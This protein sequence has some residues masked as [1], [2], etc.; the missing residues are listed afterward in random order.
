MIVAGKGG[1]GK[2]TVSGALALMAARAGLNTLVVEVE[3]K[4]GLPV[5]FDRPD[6]LTYR[7]T[8]LIPA[9]ETAPSG[10]GAVSARTLTPDDALLEYLEDHGMRRISK[11]LTSTGTLEVIATAIPGIKD[12]LVLGKIKQME[13][14][15]SDGVAGAVDFVVVDAPAAGHAVTFL[16]SAH[17]LLDAVNVGPIGTQ[18]A[19]VIEFISDPKRCQ[20]LLVTLPEETPVNEVI[21]TAFHL[22]DR[23][24]VQLA[25][26]VVN[27]SYPTLDLPEDPAG[28]V[29]SIGAGL[30]AEEAAAPWPAPPSS[31]GSRQELE[32]EQVRNG[33]PSS[34]PWPR[35]PLPLQFTTDLGLGG[36][37]SDLADALVCGRGR[38]RPPPGSHERFPHQR[39]RRRGLPVRLRSSNAAR[40]SS[41]PGPGGWA[42]RP[43]P[44]PSPSLVPVGRPANLRR[45]HRPGPAPGRRPGDRR[46]RQRTP[47]GGGAWRGARPGELWAL[48][49][50]TKAT[51]DAVVAANAPARPRPRPSYANR[52]YRNISGALSGT[53]EYMAMEKLYGLHAQDDRFDLVV[54]DTPPTRHA[55]DFLDA[56]NRLTCGSS[57]TGSSGC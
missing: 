9:A 35:S 1:V 13:Q 48:M 52:F 51:F 4:S 41:A 54:V 43:P 30:S 19:E 26:V 20:V 37:L 23:A 34:S 12:I 21:E 2:T 40:S 47:P 46:A 14:A 18:S 53:Q 17:G 56:P 44:P 50:D 31:A 6:N 16:A 55:L 7:P 27:G 8:I 22:E 42:R 24:G 36:G 11:R 5:M 28:A 33:W 39:G 15:K 25:P 57:T 49:L 10:G 29:A 32:A 3:G 38:H 45:H